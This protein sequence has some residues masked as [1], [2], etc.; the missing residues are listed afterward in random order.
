MLLYLIDMTTKTP[1][2]KAQ[3]VMELELFFVTSHNS[4]FSGMPCLPG[5]FICVCGVYPVSAHMVIAALGPSFPCWNIWMRRGA[6]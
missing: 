1:K 4:S 3:V 5:I 6:D 2:S